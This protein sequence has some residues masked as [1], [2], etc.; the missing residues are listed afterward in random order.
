M[1]QQETEA[2]MKAD[3]EFYFQ[4]TKWGKYTQILHIGAEFGVKWALDNLIDKN[5]TTIKP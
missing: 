5:E 2:K 4:L 1:T 3:L